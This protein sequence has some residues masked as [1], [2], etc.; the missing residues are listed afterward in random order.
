MGK[1]KIQGWTFGEK[2]RRRNKSQTKLGEKL[3][4]LEKTQ[5]IVP[6]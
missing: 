6:S 1:V 5:E 2:S 3:Q 4:W